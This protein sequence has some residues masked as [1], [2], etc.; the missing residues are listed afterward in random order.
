[1]NK[2]LNNLLEGGD[3]THGISTH[4]FLRFI[5]KMAR[6]DIRYWADQWIFQTGFPKLKCVYSFNRKKFTIELR[7]TQEVSNHHFVG[8][9]F[10]RIQEPEGPFERTIDLDA[11]DQT[12]EIAY[13]SRGKRRKPKRTKNRGEDQTDSP[14]FELLEDTTTNSCILWIMVDPNIEWIAEVTI[15]QADQMYARMLLEEKCVVTQS[16]AIQSLKNMS[17]TTGSLYKVLLDTKAFYKIRMQPMA[18][19]VFSSFSSSVMEW[20]V[21]MATTHIRL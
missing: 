3:I 2:L 8:P 4:A 21:V 19:I 11:P 7:V 20:I 16:L 5:R 10:V 9:L 18:S 15:Q 13:H 6:K 1:L 17:S 12:F 14:A